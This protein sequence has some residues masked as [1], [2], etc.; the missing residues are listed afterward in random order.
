MKGYSNPSPPF[1]H[2]SPSLFL[3]NKRFSGNGSVINEDQLEA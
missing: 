1:T 2:P 3:E